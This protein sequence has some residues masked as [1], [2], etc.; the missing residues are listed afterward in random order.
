MHPCIPEP[1]STLSILV[2]MRVCTRMV[3]TH[4]EYACNTRIHSGCTCMHVPWSR[5]IPAVLC[6]S[7]PS[8]H[9]HACTHSHAHNQSTITH[10]SPAYIRTHVCGVRAQVFSS[11]LAF[12]F[13]CIHALFKASRRRIRY[14]TPRCMC[15][16]GF[17][18]SVA[19]THTHTHTHT[20]SPIHI[21]MHAYTERN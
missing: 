17:L 12:L 21:H 15:L 6:C 14:V 16:Y 13:R 7:M 20:H 10:A 2:A 3:H 1:L 4:T 19:H 18:A 11:V 9:V 5:H 8:R